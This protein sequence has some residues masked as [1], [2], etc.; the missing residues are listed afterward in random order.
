V[1]P[2]DSNHSSALALLE[3]G[4]QTDALVIAPV[5]YAE[6]MASDMRGF[7]QAFLERSAIPVLWLLPPEVW[8]RAG[9][10]FGEYARMRR[11]GRL[12]RRLVAD[13]LIA[14]H[15]EHHDLK[16]MTFD[17]TVYKAVFP[18]LTVLGPS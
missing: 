18:Q 11:G 1:A 5:V 17:S 14:A 4:R 7:I 10:A 16:V 3:A 15:A 6:L 12:A 9:I 8:E 13:F 2:R